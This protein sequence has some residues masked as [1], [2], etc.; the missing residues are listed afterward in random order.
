[1]WHRVRRGVEVAGKVAGLLGTV[2]VAGHLARHALDVRNA[3]NSRRA[4]ESFRN[5]EINS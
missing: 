1:M 3:E 4:L 2:A 5:Y